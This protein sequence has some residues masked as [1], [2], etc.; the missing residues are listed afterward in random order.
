M[1]RLYLHI[2]LMVLPLAL[3]PAVCVSAGV[4]AF[5]SDREGNNNIYRMNMDGTNE[6]RLTNDPAMDQT[7]VF[8]PDGHTIA[9]LSNRSGGYQIYTMNWDGTGVQAVP[10]SDGWS[11]YTTGGRSLAWSPNGQKLLFNPTY[12][13]V[14]SIN[15]DGSDKTVYI[16][17]GVAGHDL[18]TGIDWGPTDNDIFFSASPYSNG[19]D[20]H[21][22]RYSIAGGTVSPITNDI[23]PVH[24]QAPRVSPDGS[25]MAFQRGISYSG[26]NP[27]KNIYS[28][29]L[30]DGAEQQLTFD[31]TQVHNV[32]P[33]WIPG[34]NEILFSSDKSGTYQ[35]WG[36]DSNGANLHMILASP[37]AAGNN[38]EPSWSSVPEPSALILIGM[39]AVSLIFAW[40]RRN[41]AN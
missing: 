1:R 16:T 21:V 12:D 7:P 29:T 19:L 41:R 10:N 25:R 30:D 4:V 11:F 15:L 36:M 2:V 9:F 22:F 31:T 34:T 18:I 33:I 27:L 35:I 39:G 6:V 14:A 17:G 40:R 5:T 8:S 13:S 20:Q 28:L 26:G 37:G 38:M 23:A 32:D 24:S 3:I